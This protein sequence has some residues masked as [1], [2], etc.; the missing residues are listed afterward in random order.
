[1][2]I[3]PISGAALGMQAAAGIGKALGIGQGYN[4][5][6]KQQEKLNALQIKNQAE[7]AQIQHNLQLDMWDKTNYPAQVEQLKKAGLNPALLYGKGGGG[8][9][10]VG[11]GMNTGVTGGQAGMAGGLEGIGVMGMLPAQIELIK[12]QTENVKADTAKK[13]G[14]DTELGTAQAGEARSRTAS[15]E[16]QNELNKTIGIDDMA[17][18]YGWASDKIAIESQKANA[19]YEAWKAAGFGNKSFDDPESGMA[20]AMKAGME[21]TIEEL[22]QAKLINN[23]KEAEIIVKNFEARLAEQGIHP[24]SP[25]WTKLLTDML[26]KVGITNWIKKGQNEAKHQIKQ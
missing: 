18:R 10:T 24:H 26:E 2:P 13:S 22:T 19:E 12:A 21:K 23:A 15:N 1:M 14:V 9:A 16:F 7:L 5:Q 11:M 17:E 25:W 8:G 6:L 20:R 3:D 4:R